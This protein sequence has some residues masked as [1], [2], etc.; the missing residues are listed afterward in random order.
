MTMNS[1]PT[2]ANESVTFSQF[3]AE[4]RQDFGGWSPITW[5][6]LSGALRGLEEAFGQSL[7]SQ[8]T[9]RAIDRYLSRRR[10]ED[11]L[12]AATCNRYLACLKTLFKQ[13][14]IW[15][16]LDQLPTDALQMQKEDSKVP[17][18]L[19]D[20]ELTRL[21]QHCSEPTHTIVTLAADTGMRKSEIGRLR[22][23]HIDFDVGIITVH[24]TKNGRFR[25][26]PM[27]KRLR[28][29]LLAIMPTPPDP[30][31]TVFT[32][33]N[34]GRRLQTAAKDAGIRHVH[35]HRLR[36]T[37]ATRLR[38]RGIPLDRVME[39]LG[40]SSYQMVLRYAKARP[41]QLINAIASLDHAEG[42]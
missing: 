42:A 32:H 28:E 37:F 14:R 7:L 3:L 41:Q 36:H 21:L 33:V 20:D 18:A 40:H 10:R 39:L 6:G 11:G 34:I 4:F 17:D 35:M 38:D 15:G 22:W 2:N 27:T 23:G 31:A 24:K 1:L 19:S 16:Y 5:R 25:A 26:I 12:T 13:A 30:T 9:P 29:R 8:I